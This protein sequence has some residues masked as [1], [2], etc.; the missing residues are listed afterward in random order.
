[1]V[2]ER[3]PV[4]EPGHDAAEAGQRDSQISLGHIRQKQVHLVFRHLQIRFNENNHSQTQL[5]RVLN[6]TGRPDGARTT[7]AGRENSSGVLRMKAL[8]C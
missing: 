7:L 1:V 2:R 8:R 5:G 6:T 3:P 4:F